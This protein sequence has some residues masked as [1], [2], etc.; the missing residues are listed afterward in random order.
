MTTTRA[1]YRAGDIDPAGAMNLSDPGE[2]PYTR[3]IHETG[4][5]TRPWTIRQ[6]AGFR[7][8]ADSNAWFKQLLQRG[9]T[10][11]SVAFDLPTLMGCDPDSPEAMGEVGRCGVNVACADDMVRLF[12]GIPL[13]QVSTSL[14]INGPAAAVLAMYLVAAERQGVAWSDLTGT[15]QNDI[16]K[17]YM[18]QNEYLYPPAPSMRLVTDVIAFCARDVPRFNSISVSGYHIREAGS[19]ARQELAFTLRNGLEYV[20]HA[21]ASG[22]DVDSFAPRISFF[23]NAHSNF[24]EEVAKFRAARTLWA[25]EMRA[26]FG[27]S[28]PRSLKLRFH[29]QTSGASLTGRQPSNNVVRTALQAFAAVL[30]GTQSLHTN[31][32]DE[33]LGLPAPAA[34]TLALRTQQIIAAET[35][36][37]SVVDPLGGSYYVEALTSRLISEAREAFTRIDALGGMVRAVEA[38]WPQREIAETAFMSQRSI[39]SGESAIVGVNVHC[40]DTSAPPIEVFQ[41]DDSPGVLQ[42]ERI[43]HLRQRRDPR[44]HGATLDALRRAAHSEDTNLMPL[45]VDAVRADATLGEVSQ[46]LEDVWGRFVPA[47]VF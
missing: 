33:A 15:L 35:G 41:I 22:L 39:E 26:R 36:A 7:T 27:A 17:E 3:G 47:G 44:H 6:V 12:E 4:Y 14:I 42:T 29:T 19:D 8:A 38:G 13:D 32:L 45:I 34:A 28:N 18:A 37:T 43:R 23:F 1:Y 25:S 9:A 2:Y 31:S 10:G 11:L 20:A 16:L 46:A 24:F 21:V 30:G 40:D 5:R